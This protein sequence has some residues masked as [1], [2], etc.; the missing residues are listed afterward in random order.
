[1][2]SIARDPIS[3]IA[4]VANSSSGMYAEP[5]LAN[6]F[7]CKSA[8]TD[9]AK[10]TAVSVE[11]KCAPINPPI[12]VPQAKIIFQLFAL[13]SN[14]KKSIFLPAPQMVQIVRRLDDMPNDLPI[15]TSKNMINAIKGPLAYQGQG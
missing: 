4:E 15:K 7:W 3:V 2:M 5:A 8:I 9:G 13:Q 12:I 6:P 10:S 14:L 11:S 1:M